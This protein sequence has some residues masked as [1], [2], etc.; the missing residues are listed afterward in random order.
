[1]T[2]GTAALQTSW[3]H[4]TTLQNQWSSSGRLPEMNKGP[5]SQSYVFSSSHIWMWELDHTECWPLKN[6]CLLTVV[7]EKTLESPLNC[8][9]IK[10]V[11]PK[12][13]QSW[14][15]IG[16]T[17]TEAPIFWLPNVKNWLIWKDPDA[18]KGWR[19]EEK[20]MTED[21]MVGLHHQLNGREFE[22][23]PG[24]GKEQWRHAVVH[25]VTKNRTG[26]SD[27]TTD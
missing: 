6:W 10:A 17:D 9:E 20:G 26:L 12:G 15:F 5:S 22:Q 13:N 25:G 4:D 21:E 2:P 23:G 27:W 16:K 24:D 18:G 19:W 14:I 1:M 8:K 11:N 7:F 3:P